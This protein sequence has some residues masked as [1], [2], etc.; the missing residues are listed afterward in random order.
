MLATRE[1]QLQREFAMTQSRDARR[2]AAR[3]R[4]AREARSQSERVSRD[5]V[6][7]YSNCEPEQFKSVC[8]G[9]Q[10][11]RFYI[12]RGLCILS[13]SRQISVNRKL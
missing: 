11:A 13:I 2:G 1:S 12:T 7:E 4:D 5:D 3:D 9:K 10:N 8:E 6:S